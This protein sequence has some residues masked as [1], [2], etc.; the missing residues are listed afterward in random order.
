MDKRTIKFESHVKHDQVP[1][2]LKDVS[3]GLIPYEKTEYNNQRFPI[4]ALEYAASRVTI[5][6]TDIPIN[7]EIL[8]GEVCYFYSPD[9]PGDLCRALIEIFGDSLGRQK[10]I[11][12]AE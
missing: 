12:K 8:S 7:K 3:I 4:K 6:A 1:M 9:T 5:L 2:F 11:Q 10:R